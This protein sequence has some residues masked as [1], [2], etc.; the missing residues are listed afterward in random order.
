[1]ESIPEQLSTHLK[2]TY[3][4]YA[5]TISKLLFCFDKQVFLD[6]QNTNAILGKVHYINPGNALFDSLIASVR[7]LYRKEMLKGTILVSPDIKVGNKFYEVESFVPPISKRKANN[8][9]TRGLSQSNN[10]VINNNKGF[11]ERFLKKM[12]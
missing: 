8:M 6:Y 2:D 1:M 5:A 4:I 3:N 9:F 10:V 12:V 11:T 7:R